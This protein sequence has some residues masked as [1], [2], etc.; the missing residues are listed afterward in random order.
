MANIL[1]YLTWRGDFSFA[2]APLNHVDALVLCRLSYI[3]FDGVVAEGFLDAPVTIAEAADKCLALVHK[4]DA[5]RAFRLEDDEQLL[6]CLIKSERFRDL[7]LIGFRNVFDQ[8]HAEQFSAVTIRLPDNALF[9][10]FRGTDGTIAGWRED[11]NM[12]FSDTVPAQRDAVAYLAEAASYFP[13]KLHIGGHSKGGNL[14][15]YSATFCDPE[16]Q[17]RI[18]SVVNHDGP[19]FNDNVISDARYKRILDRIHTYVPQSSIIG[20]LL[21]HEEDFSIVHSTNLGIM[22]HD[23]YS[24]EILRSGFIPVEELT[25]SSRFIDKTLKEWVRG[26]TDRKSVM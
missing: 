2:Q 8:A 1:D 20:M 23:V 9:V 5:T 17:S 11:F 12:S 13:G 22:Q 19:G 10:A 4:K 7:P 3:P 16:T 26:M 14:A 25:N 6:N 21:E 15:V 18:A 24:W